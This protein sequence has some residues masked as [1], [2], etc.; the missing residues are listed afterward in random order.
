MGVDV[1]KGKNKRKTNKK[2]FLQKL[3]FYA[4]YKLL[5]VPDLNFWRRTLNFWRRTLNFWRQRTALENQRGTKTE[6][7][8]D[9]S[10][11]DAKS[12]K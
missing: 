3:F 4:K 5:A 1:Y 12:R 8:T 7:E 10:I 2:L 9:R 11:N 6:A